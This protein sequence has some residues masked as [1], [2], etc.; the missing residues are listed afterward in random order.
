[1]EKRDFYYI[2]LDDGFE[3]LDKNDKDFR[4]IQYEPYIPFKEYNS[5]ELSAQEV[6]N[7][8]KIAEE[9]ELEEEK[10]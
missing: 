8:L 10:S 4:I 2:I 6:I 5:Y 9:E 3:V 7:R 1:M